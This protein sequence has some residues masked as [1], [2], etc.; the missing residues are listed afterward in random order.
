MHL[1]HVCTMIFAK[2]YHKCFCNQ[3]L[4]ETHVTGAVL[5]PLQEGAAV[6][7]FGARWIGMPE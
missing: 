3:I 7:K 5:P 6:A 1:V 4:R 2:N